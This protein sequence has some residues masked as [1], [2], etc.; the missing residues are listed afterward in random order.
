LSNRRDK[1]NRSFVKPSPVA[2]SS[3]E[4]KALEM[5]FDLLLINDLIHK[6]LLKVLGK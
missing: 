5:R 1:E 6:Y 3:K 4:A 2:K